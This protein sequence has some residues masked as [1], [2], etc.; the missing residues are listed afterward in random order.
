MYNMCFHKNRLDS[1]ESRRRGDSN[2]YTH[3]T[4]IL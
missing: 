4:I 2:E 3:H 1:L